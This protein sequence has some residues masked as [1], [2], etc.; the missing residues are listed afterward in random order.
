MP[1]GGWDQASLSGI[2][3]PEPARGERG[4]PARSTS[5]TRLA[6]LFFYPS[7]PGLGPPPGDSLDYLLIGCLAPMGAAGLTSPR[8]A[9]PLTGCRVTLH[10]DRR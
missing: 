2:L 6:R 10:P 5:T 1:Q 8:L 7:P 9:T 3:V 4:G